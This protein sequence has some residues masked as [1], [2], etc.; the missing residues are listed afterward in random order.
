MI[1]LLLLVLYAGFVYGVSFGQANFE[2]REKEIYKHNKV[3]HK[4]QWSYDYVNGNPA[5][6]GYVSQITTFDMNGNT[7]DETSYKS[8]GAITSVV[9]Y[10]Y[11]EKGIMKSFSRYSGNKEKLTYNQIIVT[12]NQGNKIVESGFDGLSKFTNNFSYDTGNHL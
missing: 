12:D 7:I 10:T 3:K 1:R 9:A 8:N 11:D 2:T 4:L 6:K 5:A